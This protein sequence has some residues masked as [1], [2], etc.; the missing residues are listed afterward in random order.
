MNAGDGPADGGLW[1]R[2]SHRPAA[3]AALAVIT[4]LVLLAVCAPALVSVWGHGPLEQYKRAGGLSPRG[5]P[6]GP[7]AAFWLGSDQQ[8]RD[9][10]SR[11]LYGARVSLFVGVIATVAA[12]AV[13]TALGVAAGYLG[14]WVDTVLSR[15][16]DAVLSMP[17]LLLAIALVAVVGPGLGVTIG[18]LA[19]VSWASVGRLVRGL[20]RS[21]RQREYVEAA[22]VLGAGRLRIMVVDLLPN[23]LAPVVAY[24]TLL[25]PAMVLGEATLS[26]IGLGVQAPQPSWGSILQD[27]QA[28]QRYLIAP[29]LVI[30][31]A[32][33]ILVTTFAFTVLG[34]ALRDALAPGDG[35]AG[36]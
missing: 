12:T 19:F 6:V 16:M 27:A 23:V 22:R 8:G 13:G 32:V 4:L 21:E 20:T 26:Y 3:M 29:W 24:A 1:R 34:D 18:V 2:L 7:R 25:F 35:R 10:L 28:S 9:V 33:A 5:L 36:R 30:A 17:N 14:G 15:F 31:P 11:L